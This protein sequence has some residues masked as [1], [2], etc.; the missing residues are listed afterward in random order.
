M[1]RGVSLLALRLE[2][3]CRRPWA[4]SKGSDVEGERARVQGI[5]DFVLL[6]SNLAFKEYTMVPQNTDS[7]SDRG[8]T[9][10]LI[11][12]DHNVV[13]EGIK[14]ALEDH[15]EFEVVGTASDG[16]EAVEKVKSLKPDILILDVFM[17]NIDGVQAAYEIREKND[18]VAILVFT[19]HAD[20]EYVLSLYRAGIS[21]YVFKDEPMSDLILALRAVASGG[22]YYSEPADE[23]IHSHMQDLELGDAKKAAEMRDGI[24]KLSLREKEVFPLLADGKTIR[25]IAGILGISPKTVESHKYNI[26]EKLN[27]NSV[28]ELTKI[29]LKKDLIKL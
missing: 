13:V 20:K 26:M 8:K 14:S 10:I 1:I 15:P 21:G 16:M 5:S 29:A 19:I 22:T 3:S 6:I 2:R 28:A 7:A 25:E 18:K 23:I 4:T 11:A 17:P 9:R 12:D 24:A 27:T